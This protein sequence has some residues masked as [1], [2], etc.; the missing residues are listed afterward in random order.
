MVIVSK[1][2]WV[3]KGR[4]RPSLGKSGAAPQEEGFEL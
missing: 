1:E 2:L 3:C 4:E